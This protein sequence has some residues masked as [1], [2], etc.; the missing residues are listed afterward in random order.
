MSKDRQPIKTVGDVRRFIR[1]L[2]DDFLFITDG[3]E[4]KYDAAQVSVEYVQHAPSE[5]E[6]NGDYNIVKP[7]TKGA[8][9]AV[10]VHRT[11]WPIKNNA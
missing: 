11:K 9:E 10:I 3:Y 4:R 5:N 6:W 2:P 8:K 1:E 7:E